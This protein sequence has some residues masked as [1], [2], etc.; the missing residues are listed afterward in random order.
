MN[1][2]SEALKISQVLGTMPADEFR[3][4]GYQFI[5]W[6]ADYF[7]NIEKNPVLPDIKPGDIAKMLPNSPPQSGENFKDILPDIDKIVMP[8]MTHWNHPNFFAYFATTGSGPV[9]LVNY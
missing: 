7:E 3:E 8:G 1:E 6:I 9:C 4:A 2:T 5:D